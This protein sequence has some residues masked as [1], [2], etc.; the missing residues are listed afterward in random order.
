MLIG[1]V[2]GEARNVLVL[3]EDEHRLIGRGHL[4][5]PCHVLLGLLRFGEGP[6]A[7]CLVAL[8]VGPLDEARVLVA[9]QA[10]E[11]AEATVWPP[12]PEEAI[13]DGDWW[14]HNRLRFSDETIEV[15]RLARKEGW[16]IGPSELLLALLA[17]EDVGLLLADSGVDAEELR[18]ELLRAVAGQEALPGG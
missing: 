3:A 5:E 16:I 10:A 8:G 9:Q 13:N 14:S 4:I 11:R 12:I 7:E 1:E 18:A 15:L 2:N 17:N 6:A